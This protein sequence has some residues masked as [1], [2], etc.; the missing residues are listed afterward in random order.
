MPHMDVFVVQHIHEFEDERDVK[1][2]GVYSSE[3]AAKGAVAR[4]RLQPGF[5]DTPDGFYVDRYTIDK[6]HWI[7]GF[8]S[9]P[10]E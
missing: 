2:I 1:L 3:D 4:L 5:L 6:D 9:M 10:R 7:D 8:V